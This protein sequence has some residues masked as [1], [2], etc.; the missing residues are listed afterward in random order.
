[1]LADAPRAYWRLGEA[2]GTTAIDERGVAPGVYLNGVALAVGGA[3]ARDTNTAARFD[4][5]DD[6]VDMG[7]PARGVL[8]FGVGDL[9]VE[10]W[11]R[12]SA[13]GERA[14][15]SK[16]PS[17]GPYWQLTVTDDS[18]QVGRIRVNASDGTF[19]RQVYGPAVRVD[20]GAWHHVVVELDR[21]AGI[22]VYVDGSSARFTA[23]ALP[24]DLSG[25][26]SFLI[27]KATGYASFLGE[28]DEV[29]VYAQ[30]LG[31]ARVA[32]HDAAGR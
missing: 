17:T 6:R 10:V 18:G 9:S 20:D 15:A 2:S 27:G 32:A 23:G 19:A 11:L 8:D 29:A 30:L 26:G 14:V 12:T 1:V 25:A 4:G 13:N 16:R 3:L 21:D 7:D 31:P 28:L 24:G 22:T 5:A